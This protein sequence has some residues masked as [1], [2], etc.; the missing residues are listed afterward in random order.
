MNDALPFTARW[1]V[2][3]VVNKAVVACAQVVWAGKKYAKLHFIFRAAGVDILR[4]Y[5]SKFHF[6]YIFFALK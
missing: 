2:F 6:N 3:N 4:L 1:G 5:T